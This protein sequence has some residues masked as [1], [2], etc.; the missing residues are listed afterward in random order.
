M[1][2]VAVTA[3]ITDEELDRIRRE[4]QQR[5][6]IE[7]RARSVSYDRK[8]DHLIVELRNRVALLIPT[9]LLQGVAGADPKLIAQ[10]E[11]DARGYGLH[12]ETLDVDLTVPG[13]V[14]GV[15]GTKQWMSQ[16]AAEMGRKGG[17]ARSTA[18]AA[19]S[20]AN[21]KL[22]GRPRKITSGKTA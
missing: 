6:K 20:R 12:W 11:M 9:Y 4:S 3:R 14:A 22:G 13:L 19:A 18:K 10:V 16:L 17:S 2:K 8:N 1:K 5:D 21:G 15:F 7:P